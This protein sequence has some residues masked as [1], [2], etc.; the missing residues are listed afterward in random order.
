MNKYSNGFKYSPVCGNCAAYNRSKR[1]PDSGDV[2]VPESCRFSA[3][4][5]RNDEDKNGRGRWSCDAFKN[6]NRGKKPPRRIK[7]H[8][9]GI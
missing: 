9:R 5:V 1:N 3:K 8:Q 4:A 6:R 2:E 7:P